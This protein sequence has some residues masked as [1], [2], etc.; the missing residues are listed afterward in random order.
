ML[1]WMIY[2]NQQF[3]LCFKPIERIVSVLTELTLGHPRYL[4]VSGNDNNFKKKSSHRA[5]YS[6]DMTW[7][8]LSLSST[9]CIFQS[10]EL[11]ILISIHLVYP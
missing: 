7:H 1:D 5:T 9:F 10:S 11:K 8:V 3:D 4:H 2:T 6:S